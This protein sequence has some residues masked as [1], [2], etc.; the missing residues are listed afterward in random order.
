MDYNEI[1]LRI[2]KLL[3]ERSLTSKKMAEDIGY[4]PQGYRGWFLNQTLRVKT[5]MEIASYLKV[6]PRQILFGTTQNDVLSSASEERPFYSP[7]YIE[8][9]LA[10]L[11]HRVLELESSLKEEK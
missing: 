1:K 4:T 10:Q 7:V 5:I 8:D 9:R 6:D 11:E 2:K 3:K